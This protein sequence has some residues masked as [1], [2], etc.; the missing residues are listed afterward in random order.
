MLVISKFNSN[1]NEV[2]KAVLNFSFLTRRFYT[3]QKHKKNKRHTRHKRHKKHQKA[4]K[5]QKHNKA[6]PK[7]ANKQ[8]KIKNV[9]K[10]NKGE[11]VAYFRFCACE[12]EKRK[13]LYNGNVDPTKLVKV[14]SALYEQ[15]LVY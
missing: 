6:K 12:E 8:T 10:K 3:H 11:K 1:I 5:T 15:K 7:N 4:L 9:H 13:S 14:L 2:I